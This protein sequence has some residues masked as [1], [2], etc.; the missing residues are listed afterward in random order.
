MEFFTKKWRLGG[1]SERKS[2]EIEKMY[3]THVKKVLAK[4][5]V[6]IRKI[7]EELYL[8]DGLIDKCT[9]YKN[10]K[11]IKL[12]LICG[13]LQKGYSRVVISYLNVLMNSALT[14]KLKKISQNVKSEVLDNEIDM[15]LEG[16]FVHRILFWP[17][18]SEVEIL[19]NDLKVKKIKKKNRDR[20][21][22]SARFF[23]Q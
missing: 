8:H 6:H 4:F 14:S 3:D 7:F 13:D 21:N 12:C 22:L 10:K 23:E 17:K 1:F 18:F 20:S 2:K 15:D 9:V 5:P 11:I 16:R 19:F